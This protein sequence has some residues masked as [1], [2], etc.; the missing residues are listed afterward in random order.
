MSE[1]GAGER[2]AVLTGPDGRPDGGVVAAAP[3]ASSP[4]VVGRGMVIVLVITAVV[5]VSLAQWA[6]TRDVVGLL[7][8]LSAGHLL[9]ATLLTLVLPFSHAW[10]FQA[11]LAATGH[12]L[13]FGRA[14]RLTMAV[15]PISSLTP[16]KSGD[17]VKAY[18]LQDRVPATI[19]A[20][21][22][23][24][25]RAVDLVI[26]GALSLVASLAFQVV[27]ISAFSAAVLGGI[28]TFLFAVVPRSER[29]P[30]PNRWREQMHQLLWS[31]RGI[32]QRPRLLAL[33]S[34]LTLLNYAVTVLVTAVLFSGLGVD[35][36][37]TFV[38]A[39]I[40]PVV[41]AGMLPFTLAGM[42]TRDSVLILLFGGYASAAQSLSVGLLHALFFR[43]LLSLL[44]L[45]FLQQM[46]KAR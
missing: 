13:G 43:W 41:F 15:W 3:R 16:A 2:R 32:A 20:G 19:T 45:P 1:T 5:L 39:A 22:L 4:A 14:I 35:V 38:T 18:Y 24:A 7:A 8:G 40:L 10:R 9:I 46:G 42:G 28:L 27:V 37:L 36:P 34:A 6:G 17:L 33:M 30:I 25:E 23:L 21:A 31:I 26:W 11:A 44:G 12:Q 29:L